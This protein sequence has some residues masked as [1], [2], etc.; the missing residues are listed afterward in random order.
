MLRAAYPAFMYA[1]E[2][3]AAQTAGK[4]AGRIP[5]KALP[6]MEIMQETD[7]QGLPEMVQ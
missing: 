2:P 6:D 7:G 3:Q 4:A 1:V 5:Q